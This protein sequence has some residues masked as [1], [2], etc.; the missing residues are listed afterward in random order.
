VLFEMCTEWA[1]KDAQVLDSGEDSSDYEEEAA[2]IYAAYK[3]LWKIK[4]P[5]LRSTSHD[6]RS[7]NVKSGKFVVMIAPDITTADIPVTLNS[8]LLA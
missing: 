1:K 7:T 4:H 8:Y 3:F 5:T 6:A 2:Y